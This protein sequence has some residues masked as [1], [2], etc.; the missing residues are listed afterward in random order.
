MSDFEWVILTRGSGD[1]AMALYQ[2]FQ[3]LDSLRDLSGSLSASV[4]PTAIKRC[5]RGCGK[6]DTKQ[7]AS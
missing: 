3:P 4:S 1:K 7:E 6:Y 5:Q 2:H